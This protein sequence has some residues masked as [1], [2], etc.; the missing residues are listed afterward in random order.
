MPYYH[1]RCEGKIKWWPFLPIPSRC[2]KCNKTWPW[3]TMYGPRR[4]DMRYELLTISMPKKGKTSY[5][6]WANGAPPGVAFIASRLPSWPRWLRVSS[7]LGSVFVL[8]GI[9]Y[10]L[11]LISWVAVVIGV[12][13]LAITPLLV[14]LWKK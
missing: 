7:F 10:G 4:K 9:F 3:W 11:Y 12:V 14:L 5:A 8:S 6:R 13:T 2:L 1:V